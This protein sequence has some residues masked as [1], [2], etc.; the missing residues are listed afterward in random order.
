[1]KCLTASIFETPSVLYDCY[2]CLQYIKL[3]YLC[4][5]GRG[6]ALLKRYANS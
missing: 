3:P 1:M 4:L 2:I 6:R 5:E